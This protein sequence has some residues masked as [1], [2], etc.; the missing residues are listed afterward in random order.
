[1]AG[2]RKIAG[3]LTETSSTV[4]DCYAVVG[5]GINAN[6]SYKSMPTQ[7]RNEMISLS[8]LLRSEINVDQLMQENLK[9]FSEVYAKILTNNSG[10][11]VTR[12]EDAH[13][14]AEATNPRLRR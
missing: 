1:M 7:L 13:K 12:L 8:D 10:D 2:T 5:F 14:Y 3:I 11:V 4:D 6:N 9:E